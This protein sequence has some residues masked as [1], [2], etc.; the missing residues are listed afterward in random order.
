MKNLNTKHLKRSSEIQQ[1]WSIFYL[2]P[3]SNI[4]LSLRFPKTTTKT[5]AWVQVFSLGG[6]P[7][8]AG[9]KNGE[10]EAQWRKANTYNVP[11]VRCLPLEQLEHSLPGDPLRD[12][13]ISALKDGREVGHLSID[14]NAPVNEGC[15]CKLWLSSTF[16]L[17]C[18]WVK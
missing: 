5:Q 12:C 17:C 15:S 4:Y 6:D 11:L 18:A 7:R 8:K 10:D 14:S 2:F 16:R 13:A 1:K 3:T 9:W